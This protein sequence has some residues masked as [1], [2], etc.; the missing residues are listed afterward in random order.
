RSGCRPR[1]VAGGGRGPEDDHAVAPPEGR[2]EAVTPPLRP[3]EP[4][5]L[6]Q[7]IHPAEQLPVQVQAGVEE[8]TVL[9]LVVRE[10]VAEVADKVV[11]LTKLLADRAE[12]GPDAGA[13]A[14][15]DLRLAGG[16]LKHESADDKELILDV[17]DKGV[18]EPDC[19]VQPAV[20]A[21]GTVRMERQNAVLVGNERQ[22]LR[23]GGPQ[24]QAVDLEIA[25]PE[26]MLRGNVVRD[27]QKTR[28][29]QRSWV[30]GQDGVADRP[31]EAGERAIALE[32]A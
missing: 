22:P 11:A 18:L 26:G 29:G 30:L 12:H 1:V 4:V 20:L 9:S 7:R 31:D 8:A 23:Q 21:A 32:K 5:Q 13:R 28:L 14:L 19:D 17:A 6:D 24:F 25:S 3:V 15:E 16:R 10:L 2:R 27:E